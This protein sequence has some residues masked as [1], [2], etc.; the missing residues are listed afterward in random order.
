MEKNSNPN[1]PMKKLSEI[2]AKRFNFYELL[3]RDYVKVDERSNFLIDLDDGKKGNVTG[4]CFNDL[5]WEHVYMEPLYGGRCP[6]WPEMVRL[7]EMFWDQ[8]QP[9][10]QVHPAAKDYI[11][12]QKYALHL[13]RLKDYVFDVSDV[14]RTTKSLMETMK[15]DEPHIFQGASGGRRYI[16]IFGGNEWPTWEAVC[17]VKQTFFG[18]D[19]PAVQYNISSEDDLNDAYLITIWEAADI[20][21]PPKIL[22]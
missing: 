7:K 22:V 21:L 10:I 9:V 8:K 4:I 5:E 3:Y 2:K 11:N 6:T 19:M 14:I 15:S 20:P 1:A 16:A 12:I 18:E 13:W 17:L